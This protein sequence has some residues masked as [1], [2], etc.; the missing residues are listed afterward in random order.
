MKAIA[1]SAAAAALLALTGCDRLGIGGGGTNAN[2]STNA[3]TANAAAGN[4]SADGAEAAGDGGKDLSG[5]ATQASSG[6]V[7]LD[8]NYIAGRWTDDGNCSLAVEFNI[9]GRFLTHDG[10]TGLWHLQNDRLTMSGARTLTLT[11][12][13]IDQDTMNVVNPDGSLGRSTRC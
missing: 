6:A 8:R 1:I 12:V 4:A 10:S 7:V 3:A 5:G 9:D 13:P 11:I 2:E